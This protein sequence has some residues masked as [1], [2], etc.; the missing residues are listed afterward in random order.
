[1]QNPKKVKQPE[2]GL[3]RHFNAPRKQTTLRTHTQHM[4]TRTTT[5]H[6][7][8]LI[9]ALFV[10]FFKLKCPVFGQNDSIFP[11]LRIGEWEQHLPWQR[12]VSVTQSASHVYYATDWAVVEID[13]TD[14]SPR[15]LTKTTGLS[16]VGMQWIRYNQAANLLF[17]A[18]SNTNLDLYDPATGNVTNLPFIKKNITIAGDK[19]VYNVAFEGTDAYLCTGFGVVKLDMI[20]AEVDFTV[21]TEQ[22]VRSFAV[23]KDHYYMGTDEGLFRIATNDANPADFSRWTALGASQFFAMGE[24]VRALQRFGELLYIGMDNKGLL[25]YNGASKPVAV[26]SQAN[27]NVRFMTHESGGLVVGWRGADVGKVQYLDVPTGAFAE[28]QGGC[29]AFRP[30]WAIEEGTRN[31]WFADAFERFRYFNNAAGRCDQFVYNSPYTHH[32]TDIA[33]RDGKVFVAARGADGSLNPKGYQEGAYV[34]LDDGKWRRYNGDSNPELIT[35]SDTHKDWWRIA[36]HPT[37]ERFYVGSFVGGVVEMSDDG[38]NARYFDKNNSALLDAGAAGTGR[39][40]IGGFAFDEDDN[41]WIANYGANKPIAVMQP[42]GTIRNFD[43]SGPSGLLQVAIDLNGYKWFAS[44]FD[45]GVVVFDSGAKLDDPSDDRSRSIT[46]SNSVLATNSIQ[47]VAADLD[48]TVWVGTSA[49]LYNFDCGSNLFDATNPCKGTRQ[50]I[51]VDGFGGYLLEDEVIRCIAVD[52]ANRKWV[53]T[54]NGIYVQSSDGRNT[55]VRFTATNSPLLDNTIN[56]IAI[57]SKTGEVWIGTASGLQSVRMEATDGGR[58][59]SRKAYAY[60]N[61][62]RPDYDGPIAIYGLARDSNIKITDIQGR[63]VYEGT[64]LGGQAVWNGRDYLG[65]RAASGVYLI[66]ATSSEVFEAPDTIITKIVVQN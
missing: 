35:P 28:V 24:P 2:S 30:L 36:P 9:V 50:I 29:D 49:G 47:S 15:Y 16:D 14:R 39:T 43:A 18:Y 33:L 48:G 65:R 40:A 4:H 42:D 44:A 19:T 37:E 6:S 10:L 27:M 66:Y 56:D 64:A 26:D 46:S 11:S 13:K 7:M 41:L 20:R 1:V 62:V 25:T 8:R 21:F 23:Y 55:E 52:G 34:R 57:N 12:A 63:L 54:T 51:T 3:L 17:I 5:P 38:S 45:G 22:K 61:P 59:Q 53:G 58:I 32:V 60:P 31:F